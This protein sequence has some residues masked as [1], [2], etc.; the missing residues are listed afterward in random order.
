MTEF[1][2]YLSEQ[3]ENEGLGHP[4]EGEII[5]SIPLSLGKSKDENGNELFFMVNKYNQI[6]YQFKDE[7]QAKAI[8]EMV[9]TGR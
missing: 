4:F 7:Y 1:L 6:V 8:F 5:A 9:L 3:F 2:K